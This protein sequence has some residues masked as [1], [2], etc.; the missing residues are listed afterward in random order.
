MPGLRT[1]LTPEQL[2]VQPEQP[3]QLALLRHW[4]AEH[5]LERQR[6]RC[7]SC[8]LD[9]DYREQYCWKTP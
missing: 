7:L 5:E 3:P 1:A 6:W 8:S 4:V 2:L 9:S